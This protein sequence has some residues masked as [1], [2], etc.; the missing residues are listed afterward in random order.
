MDLNFERK[1]FLYFCYD[2]VLNL[3]KWCP[4]YAAK[5]ASVRHSTAILTRIKTMCHCTVAFNGKIEIV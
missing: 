1:L 5:N 4:F 3:S 2:K